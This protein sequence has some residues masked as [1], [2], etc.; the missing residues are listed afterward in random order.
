[1]KVECLIEILGADFYRGVPDSE[2]KALCNF[3][4]S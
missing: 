1:M 3:L 4:M 2:L